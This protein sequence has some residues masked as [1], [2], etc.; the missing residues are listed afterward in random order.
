MPYVKAPEEIV[1]GRPLF[2]ATAV[3]G[4]RIRQGRAGGEPH[5]AA[6]QDRGQ[7]G[8]SRRA[9]APPTCSARPRSS[10]STTPIARRRS[11]TYRRDPA[12]EVFLQRSRRRPGASR[13]HKGARAC[14][15]SPRPSRRPRS[16]RQIKDL[17]GRIPKPGGISTS[18]G[19][20]QR[21]G[22]RRPRLRRGGRDAVRPGEGRRHPGPR[23]RFHGLRAGSL[24][25][26]REFASRRK[27][28]GEKADM[29]R[30]YVVESTAHGHGGQRRPSPR[31]AA[32]GGGRNRP[33]RCRGAG[34]RGRRS[35]AGPCR[36]RRRPRPGSQEPQWP[37][38][39]HRRGCPAAGGACPGPRDQ[40]CPGDRREDRGPHGA[41]RGRSP[42][43]SSR[44]SGPRGRH[45]RG[46]GAAPDHAGR[47]PGLHRACRAEVRR[48]PRQGGS[49]R[50]SRLSTRT[51]PPSTAT[52]TSP[53][54]IPSRPGATRAPSTAP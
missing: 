27:V 25:Y 41:C 23:R 44:P 48:R 28:R 43:T 50:P 49:A 45:A 38:R 37:R 12:W 18:P 46:Q 20:R 42:S 10:G 36:A 32:V 47:Q 16:P 34:P 26:I 11:C 30:L 14:A 8:P 53:R 7:P 29:N 9:S 22:R 19:P 17:S 24:R 35:H 31:S 51:R 54:P 3:L 39:R 13:A 6:H 33:G 4:R 2:F 1:P 15:S 52:G 5:G 40:P 21:A